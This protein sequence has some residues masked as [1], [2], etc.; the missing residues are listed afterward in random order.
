MSIVVLENVVVDVDLF[1]RSY[2]V[3][4]LILAILLVDFTEVE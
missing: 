1:R 4:G 3:I 2:L